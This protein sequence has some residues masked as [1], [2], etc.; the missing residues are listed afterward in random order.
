[1]R[2]PGRSVHS[3]LRQEHFLMHCDQL[4]GDVCRFPERDNRLYIAAHNRAYV[5][6]HNSLLSGGLD[7]RF[8][9]GTPF[10]PGTVIDGHIILA[11][12]KEAKRQNARCDT[13]PA[14]RRY[15]L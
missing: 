12:Q 4:A 1:M 15:R 13:R 14:G 8:R 7:G 2:T 3:Q 10:T 9:V 5:Q 6:R 11:E